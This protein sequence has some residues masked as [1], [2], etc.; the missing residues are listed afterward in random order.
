MKTPFSD[1]F[2]KKLTLALKEA[3]ITAGKLSEEIG[4]PARFIEIAKR[5]G[6]IPELPVLMDIC[7]KLGKDIHY[8]TNQE[9]EE[10]RSF[11]GYNFSC[12]IRC[13][14]KCFT[15]PGTIRLFKECLSN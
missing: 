11:F 4:K 2:F 13:F 6:T 12:I 9:S 1:E 14:C 10:K 7:T 15:R 8:F 3:D 5:S